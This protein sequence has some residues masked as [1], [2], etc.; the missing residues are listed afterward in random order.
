MC[1]LVALAIPFVP[2]VAQAIWPFGGPPV[3]VG[4]R[5]AEVLSRAI[6][7]P[8]VNPPGDEGA[9]AAYLAGVAREAGLEAQVVGIP[10]EQPEGEAPRR[11]LAWVRLPG[12]QD[13]AADA[14]DSSPARPIVLLS[15]LDVVEAD[16]DEWTVPPFEGRIVDGQV[17]G[18]GALDAKGVG[19]IQLFALIELAR[20][21]QPLTRDI[22]W[23]ATPDEESG[24]VYGAGWLTRERPELLQGAEYLLTE[25]GS[26]RAA[27]PDEPGIWGV[28]VTEKSPCWLELTARGPPG[29]SATPRPDAAVPRLIAALDSVRR[30]ETRVRVVPEV[31]RMFATLAPVAREEDRAGYRDLATALAED[32]AFR[33]RFLANPARNALV[34]NTISI[35]VL[36]GSSSTT[37]APATAR[38]HL[39][40]RL[41]P[42]ER[43]EDFSGA[44]ANVVAEAS[45]SVSILL[46]FP[47]NGSS[48]DTALYRAIERVA[49]RKDPGAVVVPRLTAGFTDAHYF[50]DL[51]IVAYGFVPRWLSA[52]D[53]QGIHGSNERISIENLG[54]G[55]DALVAILEELDAAASSETGPRAE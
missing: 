37:A 1:A 45:V 47:S 28:A 25:G 46:S 35:T 2:S 16:A 38:A 21:D 32:R 11:A 49:A 40:A 27:T 55:V 17:V 10:G 6:A 53:T 14:T 19:V 8:T 15:H 3:P 31:Q 50:R 26:I 36:E 7:I 43:C 52:E 51:G 22:I 29:H 24:G 18:R 13:S 30:I 34:R 54:R 39:D 12:R 20:R 23:L 48:T 44:I 4:E 41:L 9:L 5:A 42:G 33:R